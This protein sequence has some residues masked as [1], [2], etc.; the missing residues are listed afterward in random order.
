MFRKRADIYNCQVGIWQRQFLRELFKVVF[1]LRGRVN[2]TGAGSRPPKDRVPS[3]SRSS[4]PRNHPSSILFKCLWKE[5]QTPSYD[6]YA[7][8]RPE[9][10]KTCLVKPQ[11]SPNERTKFSTV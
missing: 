3:N 5:L 11:S 9:P 1:S 6:G 4:R 2:F 10:R 7:A 8:N